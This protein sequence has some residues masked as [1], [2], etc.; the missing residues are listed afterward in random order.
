MTHLALIAHPNPATVRAMIAR[1]S[2]ARALGHM[3]E[4]MEV[5]DRLT[6]AIDIALE[7]L[8]LTLNEIKELRL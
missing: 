2:S 5:A 8:G 3:S 1:I 6:L 4:A 7:P